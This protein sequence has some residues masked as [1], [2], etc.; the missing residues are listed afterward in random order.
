MLIL[1]RHGESEYNAARR[2]V[3]R[4]DPA[5]TEL[6]SRQAEAAGRLLAAERAGRGGPLR[7]VTSPLRRARATAELVAF[8]LDVEEV[9]IEESLIE[10]DYGE[11]EGLR[12]DEVAPA[13]WA[14]WRSDPA[15]RPPGGET[16]A[17]VQARLGA[18]CDLVAGEAAE[19]DLVA[20]SHVSPIKA[21]A[22]WALGAGPELA[23]RLSLGVATITRVGTKP[24]LLH[25]FGES[26][27]LARCR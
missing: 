20:V 12:S 22:A 17:E 1:L 16:L 27:H 24:P 2:L 23:W 19:G 15:W 11:L 9:E 8:S 25:S 10:L 26:G 13:D 14:A 21:A 4:S 5:L 7:V 3:G 18:W 6:G